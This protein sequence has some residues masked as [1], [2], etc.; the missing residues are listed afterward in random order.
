VNSI[1][2]SRL[3]AKIS[4]VLEGDGDHRGK[5]AGVAEVIRRASG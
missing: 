2:E 4:Y 3:L 1:D 5:A